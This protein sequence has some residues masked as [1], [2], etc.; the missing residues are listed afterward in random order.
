MFSG[1]DGLAALKKANHVPSDLE[2]KLDELMI[3]YLTKMQIVN[4]HK[5]GRIYVQKK[6]NK[7]HIRDKIKSISSAIKLAGLFKIPFS[8]VSQK[9]P[10][11]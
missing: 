2:I 8:D 11:S 4:V 6:K 7:R 1:G 3:D 9:N 5:E 10:A